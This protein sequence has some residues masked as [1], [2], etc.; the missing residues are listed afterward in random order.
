MVLSRQKN[1]T[2]YLSSN[3]VD[4]GDQQQTA[5]VLIEEIGHGIDAYLNRQ[6]SPGDEGEIFARLVEGN[7]DQLSF[8]I[9]QAEDDYATRLIEGESL[10][11]EQSSLAGTPEVQ[12]SSQLGDVLLVP[13]SSTETVK[14]SFQWTERDAAFN[15]EIGVFAIDDQGRVDGIDPSDPKYAQTAIGSSTRQIIF[16]KGRQAGNWNELSFQEGS[17]LG[18]YLIQN[19]STDVWL[20]CNPSNQVDGQPI[21]F[22][23]VNCCIDSLK[24]KSLML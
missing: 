7:L 1:N 12:L 6:D 11:I 19:N 18:F 17:R 23:S 20:N 10:E 4:Q 22:F 2:V 3:L 14:L 8:P 9:L 21:A 13:G 5:A 24:R 16:A 15:N